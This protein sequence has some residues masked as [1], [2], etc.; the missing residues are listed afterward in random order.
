MKK[1]VL[2]FLFVFLISPVLVWMVIHP[3]QVVKEWL[4]TPSYFRSNV[5][6]LISSDKVAKVD[7]ARWNAFGPKKEEAISRAFYNKGLVLV[8]DLFSAL[9]YLSPRFYFQSGDGT[10]FSPNGVEPLASI[11]FVFWVLGLIALIKK[12][13]FKLIYFCLIFAAIAYFVGHRNFAF[14]FPVL[15]AY[16]GIVLIGVNSIKKPLYKK[17]SFSFLTLYSLFILIR[18]FLL[19]A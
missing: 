2:K 7:E 12:R 5:T 18:M 4:L 1:N 14:L 19:N 16:V 13:R 11:A 15:I 6:S 17:L 3:K 10:N 9:T 8:D